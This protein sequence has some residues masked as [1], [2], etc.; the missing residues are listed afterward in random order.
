MSKSWG[1]LVRFDRGDRTR[2]GLDKGMAV[3]GLGGHFL[4]KDEKGRGVWGRE[5]ETKKMSFVPRSFD[6]LMW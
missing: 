3:R 5:K 4:G 1:I 6:K 2:S